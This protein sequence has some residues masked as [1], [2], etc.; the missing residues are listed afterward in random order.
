MLMVMG[1][2]LL[3]MMVMVVMAM[4]MMMM[5]LEAIKRMGV[6]WHDTRPIVWVHTCTDTTPGR[7]SGCKPALTQHG[8]R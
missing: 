5:M 8:G 6:N 2:L 1:M 3:M 7:E 4:M